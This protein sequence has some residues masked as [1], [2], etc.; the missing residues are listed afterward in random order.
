MTGC[1]RVSRLYNLSCPNFGDLVQFKLRYTFLTVCHDAISLGSSELS[2]L[3][4]DDL[5]VSTAQH[6]EHSMPH[7][8]NSHQD[9]SHLSDRPLQGDEPGL[10]RT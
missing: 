6:A 5:G 2:W 10:S 7:G 9:N 1:Y 3:A 8:S 4:L